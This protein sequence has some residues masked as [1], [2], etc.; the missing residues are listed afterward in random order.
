[1]TAT[2]RPLAFAAPADLT[3]DVL[4]QA[5]ALWID[6]YLPKRSEVPF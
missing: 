6:R 3:P 5:E 4:A 2:T 1:M